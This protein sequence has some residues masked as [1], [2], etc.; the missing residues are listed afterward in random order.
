MSSAHTSRIWLAAEPE[1]DVAEEEEGF[2][3]AGPEKI[4]SNENYESLQY[5]DRVVVFAT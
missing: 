4:E 5:I 3:A 2:E 1:V